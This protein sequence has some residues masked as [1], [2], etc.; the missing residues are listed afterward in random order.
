MDDGKLLS[1]FL[2]AELCA[3]YSE[4]QLGLQL[5]NPRCR[6]ASKTVTQDTGGWLFQVKDLPERLIRNIVIRKAKI[7]M[8]EEIEKLETNS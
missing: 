7:G 5:N 8:V 2:P 3:D 6:I 1:P 4:L